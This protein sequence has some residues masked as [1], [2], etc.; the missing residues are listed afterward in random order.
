MTN[1][2][3]EDKRWKQATRQEEE[4]ASFENDTQF[5]PP[6]EYPCYVTNRSQFGSDGR[7]GGNGANLIKGRGKL[8][9]GSQ[10]GLVHR[11]VKSGS[12]G[13]RIGSRP[14]SLFNDRKT[15]WVRTGSDKHAGRV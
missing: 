15:S 6:L 10:F 3:V 7:G 4:S 5:T 8:G 12:V 1:I 11:R 9:P 13:L 2:E 14:G